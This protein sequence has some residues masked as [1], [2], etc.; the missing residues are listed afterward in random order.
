M[1]EKAPSVPKA[2]IS[3]RPKV[4]HHSWKKDLLHTSGMINT[5]GNTSLPLEGCKM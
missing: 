3:V 1:R 5:I 2:S 4:P